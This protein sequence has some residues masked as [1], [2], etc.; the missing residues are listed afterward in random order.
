[1]EQMTIFDYGI[2]KPSKW[3]I[4]IDN[5]MQMLRCEACD[6]RVIRKWYDRALGGRGYTHCP[7]CGKEM[8]NWNSLLTAWPGYQEEPSQHPKW[9]PIKR[10][11]KE[12]SVSDFRCNVCGEACPC[13][14]LT[15]F[16]PNCGMYMKEGTRMPERGV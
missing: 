5:D 9:T 2:E 3:I 8:S 15:D 13:H 1:M 14:R 11:E 12:Y 7:Y 6:C 10:G 4:D 16:C